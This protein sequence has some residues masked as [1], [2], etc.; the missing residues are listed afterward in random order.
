MVGGET[1]LTAPRIIEV[2]HTDVL[3]GKGRFEGSMRKG[4]RIA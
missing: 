1:T 3:R 4:Q 2:L